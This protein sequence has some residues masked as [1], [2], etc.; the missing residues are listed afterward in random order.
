MTSSSVRK[1]YCALGLEL[2]FA[3]IRFRS[4]V[5]LSVVVGLDVDPSP[6]LENI[7]W[8]G[9]RTVRLEGAKIL[10]IIKYCK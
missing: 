10:N 5:F 7:P 8:W 1:H 4:K 2:G 9:K 3:E 6:Q